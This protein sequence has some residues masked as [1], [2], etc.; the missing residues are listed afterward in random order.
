[1]TNYYLGLGYGFTYATGKMKTDPVLPISI[2]EIIEGDFYM[3]DNEVSYPDIV[4]DWVENLEDGDTLT[5]VYPN[6][7]ALYILD[8]WAEDYNIPANQ[9]MELWNKDGIVETFIY[10][11]NAEEENWAWLMN[12]HVDHYDEDG[13]PV[14]LVPADE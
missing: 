10:F 5:I 11:I 8:E 1:M 6:Q 3:E 4:Q 14:P 7:E 9:R 13:R 2:D 12:A